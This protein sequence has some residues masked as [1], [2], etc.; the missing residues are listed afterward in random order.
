MIVCVCVDWGDGLKQ[1]TCLFYQVV[2]ENSNPPI[3]DECSHFSSTI[4]QE[5]RKN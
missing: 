4:V 3:G 2:N 1:H 5:E